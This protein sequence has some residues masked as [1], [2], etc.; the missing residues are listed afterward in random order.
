MRKITALFLSMILVFAPV[1]YGAAVGTEVSGVYKGEA[2]KFNFVGPEDL[3]FDQDTITINV[4]DE[5]LYAAGVADGGATSMT[6][7]DETIPIAYSHIRKAIAADST[8]DDGVLPDGEPGQILT[9]QITE[10]NGSGTFIV[11]PNTATGWATV[12]FDAVGEICSWWYVDDTTG[13]VIFGSTNAT[14]A[15]P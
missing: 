14:I 13:W 7:T 11:T 8:Y 15:L 12:T 3:S 4:V 1:A 2:A 10:R 6:T 9:L 5:D